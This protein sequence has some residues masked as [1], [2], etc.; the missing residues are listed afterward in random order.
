MAQLKNTTIDGT[1]NVSGAASFGDKATTRQNLNYIGANPVTL[2][3]DTPATWRAL[4]MGVAYIQSNG[5]INNQ[6][7]QYGFIENRV[8]GELISQTWTSMS[9][10]G[11][12]YHREG[13]ASG[14][15]S[16]SAEWVQVVDKNNA[17]KKIWDGTWLSDGNDIAETPNYTMFLVGLKSS[18]GEVQGTLVPVFK[19]GTFI[20]GIGGYVSSTTTDY[21]YHFSANLSGNSW[22]LVNADYLWHGSE[23]NHGKRVL[24]TPTIIYGVI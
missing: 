23:S 22:T 21:T 2:N 16:G 13:N 11:E 12:T 3:T 24:C 5:I 6:P 15:Y 18:S 20:R 4:G 8:A 10:N 17:F 1:L 19:N 9:G 14:W 7:Y